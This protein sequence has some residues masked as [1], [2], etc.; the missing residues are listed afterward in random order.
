MIWQQSNHPRAHSRCQIRFAVLEKSMIMICGVSILFCRHAASNHCTDDVSSSQK[1]AFG[2]KCFV[3]WNPRS[4]SV[5]GGG[6]L[7]LLQEIPGDEERPY[8]SD[9]HVCCCTITVE[10]CWGKPADLSI[11]IFSGC[12]DLEPVAAVSCDFAVVLMVG[13]Q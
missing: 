5:G 12:N 9:P 10:W 8:L 7:V 13:F 2:W 6:P 3:F 11:I 4:W 1:W